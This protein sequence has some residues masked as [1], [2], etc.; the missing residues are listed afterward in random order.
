MSV[1]QLCHYIVKTDESRALKYLRDNPGLS[2]ETLN[3][4]VHDYVYGSLSKHYDDVYGHKH[5]PDDIC[6]HWACRHNYPVLTRH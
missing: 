5:P 2:G 1:R 6:L 4:H 3:T